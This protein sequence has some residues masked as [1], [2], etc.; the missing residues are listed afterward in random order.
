MISFI[1]VARVNRRPP[2]RF[3]GLIEPHRFVRGGSWHNRTLYDPTQRGSAGGIDAASEECPRFVDAFRQ[4]QR[5]I[6]LASQAHLPMT[7]AQLAPAIVLPLVIWRVYVRVRRNIGRQPLRLRQLKVRTVMWSMIL[8]GFAIAAAG[9]PR[10]LIGLGAGIAASVGHA[11][12]GVRLTKFE[13]VGDATYFVPNTIIGVG[14]SMLVVG[15]I[16][17]ADAGD[18]RDCAT[19]D[20]ELQSLGPGEY[21]PE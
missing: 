11:Y 3:H 6:R 13:T 20:L 2:D 1:P 12:F 9:H 17:L 18:N 4:R 16:Q 8:A 19:V 15:R 7:S 21:S 10:A 14:L 5:P